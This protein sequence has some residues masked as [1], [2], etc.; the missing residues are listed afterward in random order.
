MKKSFKKDERFNE[1]LKG[2][3]VVIVGPAPK[4]AFSNQ[5]ELID[6]Y[7]FVARVNKALPVPENLKQHIGTRTDLFYHCLNQAENWGGGK[8]D[9]D[10]LEKSGVKWVCSPYGAVYPFEKDIKWFLGTDMTEVVDFHCIDAEFYKH[11]AST[12]NTRINSGFGGIL[13]LLH[14]DIEELYITGFSFYI[15]GFCKEYR[16]K[17]EEQI[18]SEMDDREMNKI[19]RP[20]HE[21][22]PQIRCLIDLVKNDDRI[23]VDDDLKE[24]LDGTIDFERRIQW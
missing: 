22:K 23:K 20:T 11:I 9:K 19:E 24:I 21:Q 8:I 13:D 16:D 17:S 1:E 3:R 18:M 4:V 15:G 2:K 12:L 10:L 7:D 14:H 6:S 5:G